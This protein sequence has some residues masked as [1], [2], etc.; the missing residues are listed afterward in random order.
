MRVRDAH[1]VCVAH[2]WCIERTQAYL[3]DDIA[4]FPLL[5]DDRVERRPPQLPFSVLVNKLDLAK[6]Y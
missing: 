1:A 3:R 6:Q 5:H 4:V 2:R